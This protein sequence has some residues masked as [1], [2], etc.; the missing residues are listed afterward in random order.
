VEVNLTQTL[1][2][3][4]NTRLNKNAL[5]P[6]IDVTSD[7]FLNNGAGMYGVS[8]VGSS[9]GTPMVNV[10]S[11]VSL[12]VMYNSSASLKPTSILNVMF[13]VNAKA[14]RSSLVNGVGGGQSSLVLSAVSISYIPTLIVPLISCHSFGDLQMVNFSVVRNGMSHLRNKE[15][16]GNICGVRSDGPALL[17]KDCVGMISSSSLENIDT[18]IVMSLY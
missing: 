6:L 5:N 8:I 15:D 12:H 11:S 1:D 2:D 3:A 10:T 18:G 7:S 9:S 13:S 17:L 16:S 4:L 14:L